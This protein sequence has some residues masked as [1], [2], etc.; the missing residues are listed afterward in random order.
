MIKIEKHESEDGV[1]LQVEGRLAGLFVPELERIWREA[2]GLQPER[3]IAVDLKDVTCVDRSGR[4]LLERMSS[5][6]VSFLHAGLAIQD[7]LDQFAGAMAHG[8][9]RDR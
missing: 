9:A 2:R 8:A 3:R 6:G 4:D 7:I 5:G 1:I